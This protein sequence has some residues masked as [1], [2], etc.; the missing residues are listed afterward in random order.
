[1]ES[2]SRSSDTPSR[3]AQ[4]ADHTPAEH[5]PAERDPARR[6][7]PARPVPP[8]RAADTPTTSG[9][10]R[11]TRGPDTDTL[12]GSPAS[13]PASTAVTRQRRR[14]ASTEP[15]SRRQSSAPQPTRATSSDHDPDN[16][17]PPRSQPATE[18]LA[19][20]MSTARLPGQGRRH[21]LTAAAWQ[22][23]A[24]AP[25]GPHDLN[26]Y[27]A[28]VADLL[29]RIAPHPYATRRSTVEELITSRLAEPALATVL[30][31]TPAG[32]TGTITELLHEL[33]T[34]HQRGEDSADL[35]TLIRVYLLSRIEAMW[36]GQTPAYQTDAD[37]LAAGDLV[38]LDPLRRRRMLRFRYRRQAETLLTRLTRAAERRL[39]AGRAPHS[40]GLLFTRARPETVELLNRLARDFARLAPPGTPPLWVTSLT[41]SLE[42][43]HRLR[44]LGYLALVPSAHCV[45]YGMDIEM[46]WFRRFDA[47]RA[48]ELV[49]LEHQACGAV[50]VIDLGQVWH[51]CL[52][53]PAV[54]ELQS[55]GLAVPDDDR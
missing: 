51:V 10:A 34:R 53:P 29:A 18:P 46:S 55:A 3:A 43:Q 38:D 33:D 8:A 6:P 48:L 50:N 25:P 39:W 7:S 31:A 35:I 20:A 41:R 47:H 22:K 49:L 14:S 42:H 40:S 9:A 27:R 30:A 26:T 54:A 16:P 13:R 37:V 52:S 12:R 32:V 24:G 2:N 15:R 28:A 23:L 21:A 19:R 44:S 4:R 36:W 1:M 45:G 11:A 5:S 17:R